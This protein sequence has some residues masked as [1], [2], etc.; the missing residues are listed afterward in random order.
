MLVPNKI[1][2][3]IAGNG[4]LPEIVIKH[5]LK[6]KKPFCVIFLEDASPPAQP[7]YPR[8]NCSIGSVGKI[9]KFF[10]KNNVTEVTL[11]GD[12][13]KPVF[14]QLKVDI[15]GAALLGKIIKSALYGDNKILTTIIKFLEKKGF[16]VLGC[17][18]VIDNI[19]TPL[20]ILTKTKPSKVALEDIKISQQVLNRL[21]EFDIGQA[22]ITQQKHVI[23]IEA[24]EG[25]DSL[26]KRSAELTSPN[27]KH[28]AVLV[29]L[30]KLKQDRRVDLPTIGLKTIKS[31]KK[32]NFAG[33]ALDAQNSL[34]LDKVKVIDA[35][36]KAGIFI[37]G[38]NNVQ[39]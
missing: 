3:I 11:I 14:S 21:S 8:V 38:V 29:K 15:Q 34:I 2:G 32:N 23:A 1:L 9:L 28:K 33:I 17:D 22:I 7:E 6:H 18:E 4:E 25:T 39:K 24:A 5:C 12:V 10:K 20:G 13:K 19:L 27:K 31:L 26:I 36:D 16:K 30:K 37:I 35:A